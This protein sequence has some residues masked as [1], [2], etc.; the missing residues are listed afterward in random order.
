M[1]NSLT[2]NANE[3]REMLNG[4]YVVRFKNP[5]NVVVIINDL[6]KGEVKFNTNLMDDKILM[7]SDRTPTY[8]LANVCD[9][10]DMGTTHVIRGEEWLPSAAV[11]QSIYKA[12]GWEVPEFAHLPLIMNPN[13]EGKL[14]KRSAIK[15][16]IP[17]FP[18]DCAYGSGKD[19]VESY[20][21]QNLGYQPDAILNFL[22]LLG[23]T[24]K[25]S[26]EF[27]SMEEMISK[28]EITDVHKS[29]A[30]FDLTKLKHF[31]H[32]YIANIIPND[33]L[34]SMVNTSDLSY[35]YDKTNMILDLAKSRSTFPNDLQSIVDIFATGKST[36]PKE[37]PG[38]TAI[39]FTTEKSILDKMWGK[40]LTIH[41]AD[42]D[43]ETIENLI[44]GSCEELKCQKKEIMPT[45]RRLIA[46]GVSGPDVVSI[47]EILGRNESLHRISLGLLE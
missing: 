20:G 24:P 16:G 8:H 28:F 17:V 4:P 36:I 33:R 29:G 35:N 7:K 9:D 30:K 31:N 25:D 13:G 1:R 6:I 26:K 12:F 47:M 5:E 22:I 34:L 41:P 40:G 21:Y 46:K 38:S 43:K 11:H 10:H 32:H 42:W 14:S 18:L 37:I 45:L 15:A 19:Y 27:M 23:W 2:M 3:I 44:L 39:K